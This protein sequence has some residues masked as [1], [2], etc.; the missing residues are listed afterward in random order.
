MKIEKAYQIINDLGAAVTKASGIEESAVFVGL[1]T[2]IKCKAETPREVIE[3]SEI[4]KA[5]ML[6]YM[7]A[8]PKA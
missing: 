2:V 6:N 7:L 8:L 3:A 1:A 5:D 4:V